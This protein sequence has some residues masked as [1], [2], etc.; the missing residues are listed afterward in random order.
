LAGRKPAASIFKAW[1]GESV[2]DRYVAF[3]LEILGLFGDRSD[4]QVLTCLAQHSVYGKDA[5]AA[6]RKIERR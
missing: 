3:A 4:L 1:P 2:G 5:I 6:A